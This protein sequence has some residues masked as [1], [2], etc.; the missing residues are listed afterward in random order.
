MDQHVSNSLS[1]GPE[2]VQTILGGSG[3]L[4]AQRR[5]A[6]PRSPDI[7]DGGCYFR[8]PGDGRCGA[9]VPYGSHQP[10]SFT[11]VILFVQLIDSIRCRALKFRPSNPSSPAATAGHC[12]ATC[13][14][15]FREEFAATLSI[16]I[17]LVLL[18]CCDAHPAMPADSNG[19]SGCAQDE[20]P[21]PR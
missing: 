19:R 6:K 18:P 12:G 2:L 11:Y 8:R 10:V 4:A 3:R 1:H 17:R 5:L 21:R 13:R 20:G 7:C 9:G 14:F 16:Q 15:P